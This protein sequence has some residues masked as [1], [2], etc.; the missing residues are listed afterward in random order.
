MT[1]IIIEKTE[2]SIDEIANLINKMSGNETKTQRQVEAN[3]VT[4]QREKAAREKATAEAALDQPLG[5]GIDL[6]QP[7][8]TTTQQGDRRV[9]QDGVPGVIENGVFFADQQPRGQDHG[10]IQPEQQIE[11]STN[12][13]RR[14]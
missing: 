5:A 8:A 11:R 9:V 1:K 2:D 10:H 12:R 7:P 3:R 14:L 13:A 4:E 6:T